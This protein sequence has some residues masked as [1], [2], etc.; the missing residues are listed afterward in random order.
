MQEAFRRCGVPNELLAKCAAKVDAAN[1]SNLVNLAATIPGDF[2]EGTIQTYIRMIMN[3][4]EL[5][6]RAA[7]QEFERAKQTRLN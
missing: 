4:E 7:K 2:I 6:Q 5:K 3:Y 1:A